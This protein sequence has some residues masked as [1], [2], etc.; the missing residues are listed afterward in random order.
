[1]H[2]MNDSNRRRLSLLAAL[3]AGVLIIVT[4]SLAATPQLDPKDFAAWGRR[5]GAR[6]WSTDADRGRREGQ[7][8]IG[9]G[10]IRP[11]LLLGKAP[12]LLPIWW[13]SWLNLPGKR[14]N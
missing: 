4:L 6:D 9:M 5:A 8:L 3:A 12:G 14:S 11:N 7:F 13:S 10:L 2:S 1:M